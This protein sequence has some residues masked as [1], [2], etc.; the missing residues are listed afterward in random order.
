M[1]RK[2][3]GVFM[4][5]LAVV[6]LFLALGACGGESTTS[7]ADA[8]DGA[9]AGGTPDSEATVETLLAVGLLFDLPPGWISEPT[10]TVTRSAQA[11]IPGAEGPGE[12]SVSHFG[13]NGGGGVE[14]NLERWSQQLQHV[15]DHPPQRETFQ[16]GDFTVTWIDVQGVTRGTPEEEVPAAPTHR[17]FGAVVEGEGGPWYF[18]VGGPHS[19]LTAERDGFVALLR[20]VRAE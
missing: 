16:V 17:L 13:V 20:S 6:A 4:P 1:A 14:P 9:Q 8:G 11:E 3:C 19:T 5:S 10:S 18:R 12:L 15:P 7:N 2:V